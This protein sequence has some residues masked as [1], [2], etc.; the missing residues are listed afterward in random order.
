MRELGYDTDAAWNNVDVKFV[1]ECILQN[2][3]NEVIPTTS[4]ILSNLESLY[5]V[6]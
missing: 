6:V 4:G 3:L 2:R 1:E 5:G